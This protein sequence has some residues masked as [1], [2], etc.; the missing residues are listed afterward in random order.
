[1]ARVTVFGAGAMGTAMAMHL[2][3]AGND[4]VLW[5]SEFDQRVLPDLL[6]G[7]RHPALPAFLPES[8]QVMGP[9]QLVA[10]ADGADMTVMGAHSGGA[11]TLAR[12][13]MAG[14]RSLPFL[15][16]GAKGLEPGTGKR[17]TEVY[18]E[19]VGHDHV[20][21]MAGPALAPEIAEG[22]PTATVLASADPAEAE[23]VAAAFRTATFQM[24]VTDDVVGVE[25]CTLAKNVAAIGMGIMDGL[26]KTGSA[27]YRN[28]KAALFTM[29]LREL[30]A[31]VGALGGRAE[32]ALGLAGLGDT[33]VTSLGGRNRLFGEMVGEGADPVQ[34]LEDLTHRGLT[35]EGVD[36]AREV[37]RLSRE[38]GLSLALHGQVE[39]ILFDGAPAATLLECMKE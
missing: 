30:V 10:A 26:A 32:T 34:A 23:Q 25:Y 21:A 28:A 18:A 33:L 12:L 5:A 14:T 39:A 2:A 35:V 36:A 6:N 13:V 22:Q 8:L 9:D 24:E 7:R 4:T 3:R 20:G 17:M 11:R 38:C 27:E 1:M 15:V 19:E 31:F 16:S 37:R 29:A